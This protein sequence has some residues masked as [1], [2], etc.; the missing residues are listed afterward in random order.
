MSETELRIHAI[1]TGHNTKKRKK[2]ISIDRLM[3]ITNAIP[4]EPQPP[5]REYKF[6][7]KILDLP[8]TETKRPMDIIWPKYTKIF[9]GD[10]DFQYQ[11]GRNC[12][13]TN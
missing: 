5:K 3:T 10:L 6:T 1:E 13:K 2:T 8:K 11:P 4:P 7:E 9:L 12:V